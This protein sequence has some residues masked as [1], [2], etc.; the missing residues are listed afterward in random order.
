M[1]NRTYPRTKENYANVFPD[2][3]NF[4]DMTPT[5]Q[6]KKRMHDLTSQDLTQRTFFEEKF[7]EYKE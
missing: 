7:R 1:A 4:I 3:L 6:I 2:W 5:E